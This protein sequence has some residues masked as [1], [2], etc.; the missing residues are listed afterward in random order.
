LPPPPPLRTAHESFPSCS[1]SL[2]N[3]LRRTRV[4]QPAEA[5]STFT[6]PAWYRHTEAGGRTS[7]ANERLPSF[8]C[9]LKRLARISRDERPEGSPPAFAWGDLARGLNPS[10]PDYRAA[11]ASSLI[12]YPPPHRRPPCGGP[13]PRGGRRADHVP[14][15][16]HGWLRLCLSAGGSA[17]TAGEGESPAP[18]HVPF[19]P[20]LSALWACQFSRRLSAVHLG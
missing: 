20:S 4:S 17:A 15:M 14:R 10:P 1:S 9:L 19:G 18:G 7:R 12:L 3:A 11:F 13:T 5:E 2:S 16:Y 8:A 6:I